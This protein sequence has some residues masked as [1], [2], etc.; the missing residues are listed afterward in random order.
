MRGVDRCTAISG[1]PARVFA[2]TN[3]ARPS[4]VRSPRRGPPAPPHGPRRLYRAE[5]QT[6]RPTRSAPASSTVRSGPGCTPNADASSLNVRSPRRAATATFVLNAALCCRRVANVGPPRPWAHALNLA[7]CP[8]FEVHYSRHT[9]GRA[10]VS[11][12]RLGGGSQLQGG[13]PQD[14]PVNLQGRLLGKSAEHTHEGRPGT[15]NPTDCGGP[16]RRAI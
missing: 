7:G 11:V 2:S 15:R 9:R 1:R 5:S 10:G 3:P 16:R 12:D 13:E 6:P 4:A 8:D 14:L